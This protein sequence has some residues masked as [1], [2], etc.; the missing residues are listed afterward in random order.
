MP[1]LDLLVMCPVSTVG[2]TERVVFQVARAAVRAGLNVEALFTYPIEQHEL[3]SWYKSEHI[4]VATSPH[5][6]PLRWRHL[7]SSLVGLRREVAALAP[8]A[9]NLHNPGNTILATDVMALR[10]AKVP[11]VICSVHHPLEPANLPSSWKLSTRVAARLCDRIVVTSPTLKANM[12]SMGVPKEVLQIVPLGVEPLRRRLDRTEARKELGI[13]EDAFVVGGLA[14]MEPYKRLDVLIR[15]CSAVP[16][17]GRRGF[18]LLA[19]TGREETRLRTLAAEWLPNGHRFLG[20]IA[21]LS[22]FYASLDLFALLSE[23][24]GFGLVYAEAGLAG[25]PSAGCDAGGARFAI[26]HGETGILLP[27]NR[28]E[29]FSEVLAGLMENPATLCRLGQ[30]AKRLAETELSL[31]AFEERYLKLLFPGRSAPM[32]REALL[33]RTASK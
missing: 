15:A 29:E 17:F 2:G 13:P 30:A 3:M 28:P 33:P 27:V 10:L 21:D 18:L 6:K 7:L 11:R 8:K 22:A 1:S 5:L 4:R 20:S 24:E 19:G 25:A 16:E 9:V 32:I 31:S 23:L 26:R 12:E 14:R